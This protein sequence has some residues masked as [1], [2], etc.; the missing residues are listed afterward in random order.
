MRLQADIFTICW[1]FVIYQIKALAVIVMNGLHH[2]TKQHNMVKIH[3]ISFLLY[4][5]EIE[6]IVFLVPHSGDTV[7]E[8]SKSTI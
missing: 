2:N 8:Y 1:I 7:K 4:N 6:K 5:I 3:F